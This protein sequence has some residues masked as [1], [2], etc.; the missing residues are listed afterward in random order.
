[1][2]FDT[3]IQNGNIIDGTGNPWYRADIGINS[4]KISKIGALKR[5]DAKEK[6]DASD[7]VVCPGFIDMHSHSDA[8]IYFDNTLPST[9]RQ[10][11]TTSLVGNCGDNLAPIPPEKKEEY[12]KLYAVFAPPGVSF[13]SIPWNTFGEY[14]DYMEQ[15]RCVANSAHLV[16]FGTVRVAG[17]PGFEDRPPT[18]EEIKC[19][20]SFV[21]EA[22]EN[23]AFGISTGLI[24]APQ[25]YAKTD[26]IIALAKIVAKCGGIYCS[27]IRGEGATVVEAVNEVIEITEK[28]GCTG[29][30]I[31]HHK[32]AGKSYWGKSRE[33]LRLMQDA[34]A[35]GTS[36][37]CDQYPYNRGMTSLITLLPPWV[38]EGGLEKLIKRLK[39][40]DDRIRIKKDVQRGIE[41]WENWIKDGG[42]DCIYIASVKTEKWRAVEGKNL[43]E[44]TRLKGKADEWET[45]F[46]LLIDE[47]GEVS[48][49]VELM[50]EE[51]IRRIMT[52]RYTM[53]GTDAWGVNPSGILRHGKPHPRYYGT[54]PRILGKYVREEG[55]LT[56]ENAIRKMTSFPAQR[57]GLLDRSLLKEGM[58][59]DVVVFDPDT[60][61]DKATYLDPHQ[62]PEGILHV[63]VNG[64]IVVANGKQTGRLPGKVLR[65]PW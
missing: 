59:A 19:M 52:G 7:L 63:L 24:Y 47:N 37:T 42:F 21:T 57:L 60:V 36:I 12:L 38:H 39:N 34:N 35:R 45:L 62:F 20:Q 6:I 41:G 51:D 32:V 22:M 15:H 5:G 10:G 3:I 48:M 43:S 30:H 25:A 58:W 13:L 14:L 18:D 17:G 33:T 9:I 40:S 61:M 46:D 31:A 64:Q 8:A 55:V 1:M 49:T 44:I 29:G 2:G 16:G 28:S 53:I 23:G 4:G 54:Y 11:I 56:L 26:E 50:N 65:R 27:H